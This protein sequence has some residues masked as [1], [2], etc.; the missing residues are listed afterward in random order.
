MPHVQT[1]I[2]LVKL[3]IGSFQ[4][5]FTLSSYLNGLFWLKIQVFRNTL[6]T[7]PH[8]NNLRRFQV[9]KIRGLC[10]KVFSDT[11]SILRWKWT[12]MHN[13]GLLIGPSILTRYY[14]VL[15]LNQ[16]LGV[17]TRIEIEL[18]EYS[19]STYSL[20]TPS[21]S[22]WLII[23]THRYSAWRVLGSTMIETFLGPRSKNSIFKCQYTAGN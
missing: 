21:T 10:L 9:N 18:S 16:H 19:S 5:V 3:S 23:M 6:L 12:F 8:K 17:H 15:G 22:T 20:G 4:F 1:L 7:K 14:N 13:I 11:L 2:S